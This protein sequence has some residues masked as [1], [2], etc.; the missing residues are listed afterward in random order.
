[1][2]TRGQQPAAPNQRKLLASSNKV[3]DS[4]FYFLQFLWAAVAHP[5]ELTILFEPPPVQTLPVFWA[6]SQDSRLSANLAITHPSD[7]N[8]L[9]STLPNSV[10]GLDQATASLVLAASSL[11]ASTDRLVD[12]R[13]TTT[14]TTASKSW[15]KQPVF[16]KKFVFRMMAQNEYD[17]P[18]APTT[19]LVEFLSLSNNTSAA[20]QYIKNYL[21]STMF[22]QDIRIDPF[23]VI[24]LTQLTPEYNLSEGPSRTIS[25]L[26]FLEGSFFSVQ[27]AGHRTPS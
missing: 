19:T 5:D 22:C 13:L 21:Q 25:R 12:S 18:Q 10:V 1:M 11:A 4:A 8:P 23:T 9:P 24:C 3:W 6:D 14:A 17:E 16:V 27:Q 26:S 15:E 2:Q 7:R 20:S